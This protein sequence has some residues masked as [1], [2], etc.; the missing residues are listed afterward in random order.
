MIIFFSYNYQTVYSTNIE[1]YIDTGRYQYLDNCHNAFLG[2]N[3]TKMYE[4]N[5]DLFPKLIR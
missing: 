4:N 1:N 3:P 5:L 2:Q